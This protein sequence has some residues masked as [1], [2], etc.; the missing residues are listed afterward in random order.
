MKDSR[1]GSISLRRAMMLALLISANAFAESDWP[2]RIRTLFDN[3]DSAEMSC[4]KDERC[5]IRVEVFGRK[6]S[7][8]ADDLSVIQPLWA[9]KISITRTS[10]S[11]PEY[12]VIGITYRC[13]PALLDQLGNI[14]CDA[15]IDV[16][17][18]KIA[19]VRRT[20]IRETYIDLDD[21]PPQGK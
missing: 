13:P 15:L 21:L 8:S 11:H 7:F 16:V 19:A 14:F 18:G 9:S 2:V 17:D 12:F 5:S 4:A 3:G 20:G 6:R 1:F 10:K